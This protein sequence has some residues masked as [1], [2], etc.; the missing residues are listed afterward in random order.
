MN[1][2]TAIN[3]RPT[4]Q[5]GNNVM[6]Q[7]NDYELNKKIKND[8]TRFMHKGGSGQPCAVIIDDDIQRAHNMD[9]IRIILIVFLWT[10]SS[11]VHSNR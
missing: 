10:T 2:K 1:Q 6:P 11:L 4:E 5:Y 8:D 7:R 3:R 9:H